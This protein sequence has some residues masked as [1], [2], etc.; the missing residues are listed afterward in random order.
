MKNCQYSSK[1]T[2]HQPIPV[3]PSSAD[4]P[5]GSPGQREDG[6]MKHRQNYMARPVL[7][8]LP[9]LAGYQRVKAGLGSQA[10]LFAA[11]LAASHCS[12]PFFSVWI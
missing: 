5:Q 6:P 12:S 4:W 8:E 10:M 2:C 9:Y 1:L 7:I 3:W 11:D